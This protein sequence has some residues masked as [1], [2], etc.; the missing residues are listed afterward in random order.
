MSMRVSIG[1][2][3]RIQP[4][5]ARP[6]LLSLLVVAA[7]EIAPVFGRTK[8][9]SSSAELSAISPVPRLLA[10]MGWLL[11]RPPVSVLEIQG[12]GFVLRVL[13]RRLLLRVTRPQSLSRPAF[14]LRAESDG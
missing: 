13:H 5:K 11:L 4:D 8:D 3:S 12:L 10:K 1:S 7:V 14:A 6:S 2:S 9:T